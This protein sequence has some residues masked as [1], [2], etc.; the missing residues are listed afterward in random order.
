M[1]VHITHEKQSKGVNSQIISLQ[2]H[3]GPSNMPSELCWIQSQILLPFQK[4]F[5]H[6]EK[7]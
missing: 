6:R 1:K 5:L 4:L 2:A 3:L 7:D